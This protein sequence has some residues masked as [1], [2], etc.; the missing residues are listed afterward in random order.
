MKVYVSNKNEIILLNY[1][2]F[3]INP[4]IAP[5]PINLYPASKFALR[6]LT[7]TLKLEIRQN[8]DKIRVTVR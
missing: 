3:G 2:V 8:K 6:A 5:M 1:S 4:T 7:E